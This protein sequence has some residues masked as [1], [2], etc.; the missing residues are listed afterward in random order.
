MESKYKIYVAYGSNMNIHRMAKSCPFAKVLGVGEL[1]DYRLTFRGK[2]KGVACIEQCKGQKTP[3]VLW[4]VDC[5]W[6]K[7]LDKFATISKK[8]IKKQVT[9]QF[10]N[11]TLEADVYVIANKYS[12]FPARPSQYYIETMVEGYAEHGIIK[13][14]L[15]N[16]IQ[17]VYRELAIKNFLWQEVTEEWL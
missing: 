17:D 9:V 4:K 8:Y 5:R 14:G 10:R 11:N 6:A 12:E 16:A 15:F 13:D 7:F 2:R 1:E 3:V